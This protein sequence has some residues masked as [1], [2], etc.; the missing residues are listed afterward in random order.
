MLASEGA[1][2]GKEIESQGKSCRGI[3]NQPNED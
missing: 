1:E 3:R 2:G